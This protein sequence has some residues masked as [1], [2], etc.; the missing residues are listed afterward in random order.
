MNAVSIKNIP[1]RAKLEGAFTST[2]EVEH[3]LEV[4]Q[5][6]TSLKDAKEPDSLASLS[7]MN[8]I[9][10]KVPVNR[11]PIA[12]LYVTEPSPL[13]YVSTVLAVVMSPVCKP[14][15]NTNSFIALKL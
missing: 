10:S 9:L 13:V 7:R 6:S 5:N 14:P 15:T 8:T 4:V 1:T 3:G 2:T 12:M 11:S